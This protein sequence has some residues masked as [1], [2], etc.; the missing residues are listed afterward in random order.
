M[1]PFQKAKAWTMVGSMLLIS[2]A[3]LKPR[4]ELA[5]TAYCLANIGVEYLVYQLKSGEGFSVELKAGA[6]RYEWFN[7]T[8]GTT[9]DTGRVEAAESR[10][11]FK[12]PFEGDA[13]LHLKAQ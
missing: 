11:Q 4:P 12:A 2:S 6:Y 7:P 13:V 5:S 8:T 3:A 10:Q 1:R 9:A